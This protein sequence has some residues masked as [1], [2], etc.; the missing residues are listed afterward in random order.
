M[1]AGAAVG[2]EVIVGAGVRV[3]AAPGTEHLWSEEY[4]YGKFLI[5]RPPGSESVKTSGINIPDHVSASKNL[6]FY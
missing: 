3:Q 5:N 1:A 6:S 2:P 4:I